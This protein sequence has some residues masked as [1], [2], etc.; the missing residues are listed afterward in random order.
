MPWK[1]KKMGPGGRRNLF[2][3]LTAAIATGVLACLLGALLDERDSA[4]AGKYSS[5]RS[6]LGNHSPGEI[7]A[8]PEKRGLKAP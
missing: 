8:A 7:K 4:L 5:C 6:L 2:I 3:A 1:R